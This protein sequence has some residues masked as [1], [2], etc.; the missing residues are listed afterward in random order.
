MKTIKSVISVTLSLIMIIGLFTIVPFGANAAGSYV[1]VT[2]E[3]SDWSGDYLIVCENNSV[4]FN[5]GLG[6]L[7]AS[8]N[9][10]SVTINDGAIASDTA[11]DAAKFTIAKS[12]DNYTIKSASGKYIGKTSNA[13]GLDSN[14]NT[15]YAN[16]ISLN[17]EDV[18]IVSSGGAY[19]RFN[20]N[21]GQTRFRYFKS[22]TYTGQKA[23][24]LY[25]LNSSS[26]NSY[27]VTWNYHG[28][29]QQSTCNEGSTPEFPGG[30]DPAPYDE[31][32]Y[33]YTFSGWDPTPSAISGDT[34]YNA[35]YSAVRLCTVTWLNYNGD[36]LETD[37]D[38]PAGTTPEY[39][40]ETPLKPNSTEY[41][42]TFSGWS[43]GTNTYAPDA[44]PELSGD[45][46]YTA[47]FTEG[48]IGAETTDVLNRELTG[49]SSGSTSYS[50]W[51]EKTSNSSAVYAGNS[52]GGSGYIQLRSNNNNSGIVT[53]ASGG[54]AKKITITW[55]LGNQNS[56]KLDVYGKNTAYSAATDL[57]NTST[58]GTSL[59]SITVGTTE[60][61]IN[62]DYEYIGLRSNDGALWI[63]EIQITWANDSS[64]ETYTVIWQDEDGT[65]LERDEDVEALSTPSFDSEEPI[66]DSDGDYTYTFSGWT[67]EIAAVTEDITYTAVYTATPIT[68]YDIKWVNYNDDVIK[69]DRLPAGATPEYIGA[70]PQRA[71]DEYRYTFSG[72][73]PAITEVTGEATYK[74]TYTSERLYTVI[75]ENFDGSVLDTG[76]YLD[77]ETPEY[78]GENPFKPTDSEHSYTFSGWYPSV[79]PVSDDI[80][81]T[82]QFTEGPV[83][84][85]VTDELVRTDTGATVSSTYVS[86]SDVSK[87][88]GAVYKGSSAGDHDTIQLRSTNNS[89]IV[90]TTSGGRAAKVKVTWNS[91]TTTQSERKLDIYGKNTAYN[92][93]SN[94]YNDSYKGEY[95]GSIVYGTDTEF[96]IDGNYSYIGL[97]SNSGAM[98]LDK[99]EITW[100]EVELY[101]VTWKNYNGN[102]LETDTNVAKGDMPSYDGETPVKPKDETYT[103]TFSGWDPEVSAVTGDVEYTAQF[104]QSEIVYHTITWRDWDDHVLYTDVYE[105][106]YYDL[107]Y[108]HD[109]PTRAADNEY[110]YTFSGWSPAIETFVDSDATY[111]AQYIRTP[112]VNPNP[113]LSTA[114]TLPTDSLMSYDLTGKYCKN[115][116]GST[117][118]FDSSVSLSESGDNILLGND[119]VVAVVEE[120]EHKTFLHTVYVAGS[121]TLNDPYTFTP[122]YKYGN[123]NTTNINVNGN[124]KI[125]IEDVVPGDGFY[126][127]SMINV[128]SGSNVT[129]M[130]DAETCQS[131][132][133]GYVGVGKNKYGYKYSGANAEAYNG[134]G[135]YDFDYGK[136]TLYYI[137]QDENYTYIFSVEPLT[138]PADFVNE[139]VV[140]WQ[141][142]NGEVLSRETYD[143][144]DVPSYKGETPER[145]ADAKFTYEFDRWTPSISAVTRDITYVAKFKAYPIE[146]AAPAEDIAYI[147]PTNDG[148]VYSL[149]E[150]VNNANSD[151]LY[152]SYN[153][154][155]PQ[156]LGAQGNFDEVNGK[157]TLG[158]KI[159]ADIYEQNTGDVISEFVH[160]VYVNGL[161]TYDN[162]LVFH[163]NY[164][165]YNN[166]SRIE[167]GASIA[168]EAFASTTRDSFPGDRYKGMARVSVGT[169][170]VKFLNKGDDS[171]HDPQNHY[172]GIGHSTYGYEYS[173]ETASPYTFE[174]TNSTLYFHGKDSGGYVFAETPPEYQHS[175]YHIVYGK[176]V[177]IFEDGRIDYFKGGDKI[178][179]YEDEQFVEITLDDTVITKLIDQKLT[180][181]ESDVI[182]NAN[183][184]LEPQY[185]GGR[186]L[187]F[188]KKLTALSDESE[189]SDSLRFMTVLSSE[190]LTRLY[191]DSDYDFGYVFA[192]VQG[193]NQPV[194]INKLTLE[195]G[196]K[197]SC[198]DTENTLTGS[199]GDK[200]FSSTDYKYITAGVD[201]IPTGYTLAV[202]FYIT[203]KGETHFINYPAGDKSGIVF[204][205][206]DYVS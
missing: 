152:Y 101:T 197:Y 106:G 121:G 198:K 161:G 13:N 94:L 140:E 171:Y 51:S 72:W 195:K 165:Y 67:P 138:A 116:G 123:G 32:G 64:P 33:R 56:R 113:T 147:F 131:T 19:L 120:E 191:S 89:G 199:F 81:Y 139:Y 150:D 39:D 186:L 69:T 112:I 175:F 135:P 206:S 10:I 181:D 48:E 34:T 180:P 153:G 5:G 196:N 35:Q 21:S 6:T 159:V 42:Y 148:V 190:I 129:F 78:S 96:I 164:L 28:G 170:N 14:E 184:S 92:A 108:D 166:R 18:D 188:Q 22:S 25:K 156:P 134:H 124:P 87:P 145:A 141:N 53:T 125:S 45:V 143:K 174:G 151:F 29:S 111:T 9:N 1:K 20:P 15:E 46:T 189:K 30:S 137:G 204:N 66:K 68:K 76:K 50:N 59:G 117:V 71:D 58:R 93:A 60:F 2:S 77:G 55:G 144:D 176:E 70:T 99:I 183:S 73:T 62:G 177:D 4:A 91:N 17:G 104:T 44:L 163:P 173:Y 26:T 142:Y 54:K 12:G 27:N 41:S 52:A 57:Y 133:N 90:T 31:D 43:D 128:G 187:G 119:V 84:S 192:A 65:E 82:A 178:Y 185:Y 75:W 37:N 63:D 168:I 88:S 146:E 103:Y 102:V 114:G 201:E 172:I 16:S 8:G 155:T 122:N 193:D 158:G 7:D 40:G 105:H 160:T 132:Y 86:W 130:A 11:T 110:T 179:K 127:N 95:L 157:I 167:N 100:G 24:Q 83:V 47:Q 126:G 115:S 49:V 149:V 97:R 118:L 194:N 182:F 61:T 162:P 202:R 38:V 85:A 74:A 154:G 203:Y 169:S 98:Y 80:T 109:T 107:T 136:Y 200:N 205:S 23:I 36:V 79:E 3:P